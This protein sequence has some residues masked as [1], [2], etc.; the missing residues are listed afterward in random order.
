MGACLELLEQD[1]AAS[2]QLIASELGLEEQQLQLFL[3]GL[4]VEDKAFGKL[5]AFDRHLLRHWLAGIDVI[6]A[7]QCSNT[8]LAGAVE[9]HLP[10]FDA[11][12]S[13]LV[14]HFA[15]NEAV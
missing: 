3:S 8:Q 7:K 10:Y 5:I 9:R 4:L 2:N 12:D 14:D 6:W 15:P 13:Q 1:I 11:T